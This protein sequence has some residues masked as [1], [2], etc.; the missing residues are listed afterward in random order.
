MREGLQASRSHKE[1]LPGPGWSQRYAPAQLPSQMTARI[2]PHLPGLTSCK[3]RSLLA[4]V[5]SLEYYFFV[6][7]LQLCSEP[8][9]KHF[10]L[11]IVQYEAM[12]MNNRNGDLVCTQPVGSPSYTS[13]GPRIERLPVSLNLHTLEYIMA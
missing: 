4:S 7:V 1:N 12:E 2:C 11:L 8:K 5:E 13:P 9:P 3:K 6:I 10:F